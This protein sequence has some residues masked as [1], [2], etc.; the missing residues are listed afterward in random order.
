MDYNDVRRALEENH[1][2]AMDLIVSKRNELKQAISLHFF[3]IYHHCRRRRFVLLSHLLY[4]QD[5]I[6]FIG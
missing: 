6:A 2:A 3:T 1:G 5:V 4:G